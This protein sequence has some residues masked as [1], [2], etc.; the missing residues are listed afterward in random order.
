ME[1]RLLIFTSLQMYDNKV[2]GFAIT[3]CVL[4]QKKKTPSK[5]VVQQTE[6]GWGYTNITCYIHLVLCVSNVKNQNTFRLVAYV[7]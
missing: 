3:R 5:S 4:K 7:H 2:S 6:N 1:H